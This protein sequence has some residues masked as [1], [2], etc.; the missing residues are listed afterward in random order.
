M[1]K[2]QIKTEKITPFKGIL[3][4]GEKDDCKKSPA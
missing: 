4:I 2:V 3:S 1:A